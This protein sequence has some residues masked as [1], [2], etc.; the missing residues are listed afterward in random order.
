[1]PESDI[2]GFR[3]PYLEPNDGAFRVLAER[4]FL[5]DSTFME[6]MSGLSTSPTNMLWPYTLD[7]GLQQAAGPD[8]APATNYPGLFEIP[9]WAQF[10]NGAAAALMSPPESFASNEVVELWQTNFLFHYQGNR[11]PFGVYLHA[12]STDQWLAESTNLA[13]RIGAPRAF[14]GWAL[15]QPDTWFISC[16][17]LANYMLAPVSS[18]EA[19]SHPSFLRPERI[20]YPTSAVSR[21]SYPHVHTF[22]VCGSCPPAEP[23]YTNAYL[24]LVP[25]EGGAVALNVVSQ[26]EDYAWCTMTVSNDVPGLI[27]NWSVNFTLAGGEVQGLHDATVTQAGDQV[28]AAARQ[29]NMQIE[30]GAGRV[31]TFR[32]LRSGGEV[33]FGNACVEASGLGPQPIRLDLR[34][35]SD[36]AGWRLSWDDNA[37]VYGLDCS[38]NLLDPQGWSALTNELCQPVFTDAPSAD[39]APRFYRVRGTVY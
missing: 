7:H 8:C 10:T 28:V 35:L 22:S 38:T 26:S 30:P 19:A 24:G 34:S 16:S 36:P 4:Q 27:Y 6:G 31:L 12:A 1:M 15:E 32:V 29:Y 2:V 17:D 25:M 14:I 5:Y 20:P 23:T 39:G 13:W 33:S 11:A 9:L 21:C 37:Y 3:A 18:S